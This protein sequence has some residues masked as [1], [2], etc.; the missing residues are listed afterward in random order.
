VAANRPRTACLALVLSLV[1]LVS[2]HAA[3]PDP[4]SFFGHRMGEDYRLARWPRIVQYFELLASQSDRV[5][6]VDLGKTT[7]GNRMVA[8]IISSPANLAGSDGYRDIAARLAGARGLTDQQARD[9][10]ERGRAIVSITLN[11][12]STEIASSQM[13]PELAYF[14]AT[15]ESGATKRMLDNAILLLVP[16]LN[17][18]GQIMVCDWY[19]RGLGTAFE[20]G[21]LPWLYHPYAGHDN[22]RDWFMLNLAETRLVTRFL[23]ADWHVQA[24]HDQHQMG[25]NGARLFVPPYFDPVNPNV[26]P[27]IWR[28]IAV[29]GSEMAARLEEK[30]Y[31]GVVSAATYDGWRPGDMD[32]TPWWHNVVGLITEAASVRIATPIQVAP[33]S[34][35]GNQRG[36][37]SHEARMNFPNPWPGGWWRLRDIVDYELTAALGF[38]ESCALRKTELL[39]NAYRMNRDAIDR[40][41]KEAPYAFVVPPDQDPWTVSRLLEPLRYA[42]VEV[43][44]ARQPF[45]AEKVVYPAGTYVVLMAQPLRPYIKDV[46]EAQRYPDRRLYPSGPP[47]PPYDEAGWTLPLKMGIRVTPIPSAFQADLEPVPEIAPPRGSVAMPAGTRAVAFGADSNAAFIAVNRLQRA[48][49]T[50]SRSSGPIPAAGL[51]AFSFVAEV[52]PDGGAPLVKVLEELSLTGHALPAAV[53]GQRLKIPRV[54]LYQPWGGSADEGWTRWVFERFEMPFEVLH[55]AD[56]KSGALA[57]RFDAIVLPSM[58]AEEIRT[59]EASPGQAPTLPPPYSGGLGAEGAR[60]LVEFVSAGGTLVAFD[61]GTAFAIET[62]NLPVT[63]VL[64]DRKPAEFFCPG[65]ILQVSVD[66]GHPLAAG[67]DDTASIFF[68]RSPAFELQPVFADR[69]AVAVAVYTA[70]QPLQSGWILG[71]KL[72]DRRA[73]LVVAPFG[74]GEAVL[75]GFRP[76]F[77][78]QTYGTF[79]LVFNA[80]HLAGNNR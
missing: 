76:Q 79:K 45:T 56:I 5:R 9:L 30:N 15:D 7:L 3:P 74:K 38:L 66:R 80:I 73:A 34:L 23:Y 13:A 65:S 62:L 6:L 31:R 19:E 26:H 47:E 57:A 27:L 75:F 48:G 2:A 16:S 67:M 51:P 49:V 55:A 12:H 68:L 64:K 17:P 54:G 43:H 72:L 40:G 29:A 46:L 63:N 33:G 20:G 71:Q 24:L 25:S 4:A 10:A 39:F 18:D 28:E 42:G 53:P 59:G 78:G 77:R 22:N 60:S 1:A 69:P 36:M 21:R 14:L 61:A 70:E 58:S 52:R 41:A 32:T 44:R 35:Q 11:V 50:V 8:A 37:P